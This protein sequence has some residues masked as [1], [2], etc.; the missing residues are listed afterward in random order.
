MPI[1]LPPRAR[2]KAVRRHTAIESID[3]LGVWAI[4]LGFCAINLAGIAYF[5]SG[6]N[7]GASFILVGAAVVI[8]LIVRF[9]AERKETD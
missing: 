6:D 2:A 8:A 7:T 3:W 4:S 9:G 5:L 1:P